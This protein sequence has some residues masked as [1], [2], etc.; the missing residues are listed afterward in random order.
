MDIKYKSLFK[1]RK[2]FPKIKKKILID[3]L[4]VYSNWDEQIEEGSVVIRYIKNGLKIKFTGIYNMQYQEFKIYTRFNIIDS[5]YQE[6]DRDTILNEKIPALNL[7]KEIFKYYSLRK[8]IYNC[9]I[10]N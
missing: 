10:Y 7:L 1:I 9:I 4:D 6:I 5:K 2:I 8:I 3:D